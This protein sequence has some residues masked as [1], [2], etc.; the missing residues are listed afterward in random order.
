M[1]KHNIKETLGGYPTPFAF[2]KAKLDRMDSMEPDFASMFELM[3][4]ERENVMYEKSAGYRI[5]TVTYG[6]ARQAV[7]CAVPALRR[8]LPDLPAQSIVGLSMRSSAEWIELFWTILA[9]GFRPL[10]MNTRLDRRTLEEELAQCGAAAVISDGCDFSVPTLRPEALLGGGAP[11]E[12][13]APFGEEILFMSSGTS[14]HVKLCAYTAVQLR[15]QVRDS[16]DIICR[17]K[18]IYG[19]YDGRL[20]LLVFL[21]FYHVFGLIALYIWFA[22]FSRTF[23]DLP[24]LSPQTILGTI[25][26]H[27]VT[28]IFAVPLFWEKIYD[29]AVRTIRSRG[30]STAARFEKALAVTRRLGGA[31]L[32]CAAFSRLAFR[33]VRENLFGESV[34]FMIT[35]GSEI[36]SEVL[37]FFNAVGYRLTNGYGMTEIG[38]ASVELSNGLSTLSA[39]F[40]GTP[41]P[42]V[43]YSLAEDG[44]LLVR[45]GSLARWS[46][47]D[48]QKTEYD[49]GW[50]R[51]GDLAECVGGHYRILGRKDD[52]V[53]TPSGEN[54]NPA[55]IESRFELPGVRQTCL[56]TGPDGAPTLLASVGRNLPAARL[57][58]LER[59]LRDRAAGLGLAGVLKHIIPVEEDLL[60]EQDF[61]LCR[62]RLAADL[63]QGRL[64]RACAQSDDTNAPD[65]PCYLRVRELFAAA[66]GK[67]EEEIGPNTDFFLDGGGSSLDYF[68]LV[69]QLR[70]EFSVDFPT[71]E[72]QSVSTPLELSRFVRGGE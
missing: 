49:G 71:A 70:E 50:F 22:F 12:L 1:P 28:H 2:V 33:E 65:D 45:G 5:S 14:M 18:A 7:A 11:A 29:E 10:L 3:F 56:I 62:A 30:A 42:S 36:R 16:C 67:P 68:A 32:L 37:E 51:T 44:E 47:A 21:P 66:L 48:G 60:G 26:R 59:S 17:C 69:T 58:K 63:A 23:V 54:L 39:G 6:E 38:I 19:D 40:V 57:E 72:G 25:R 27:K 34:R 35:G 52:L 43:E 20:K 61:K 8:A 64:T 15:T 55:L 9:C 31:P 24:D 4:S 13:S 53:V 46:M 41:L